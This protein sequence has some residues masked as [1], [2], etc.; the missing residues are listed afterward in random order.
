M[1]N[2]NVNFNLYILFIS[3]QRERDKLIRNNEERKE[4]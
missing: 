2:V 1:Y 4:K 3:V